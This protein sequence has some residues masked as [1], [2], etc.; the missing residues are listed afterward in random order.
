MPARFH[1]SSRERS[2]PPECQRLRAHL[3]A[4]V[5]GEVEPVVAAV[6]RAHITGCQRCGAAERGLRLL[7]AALRGAAEI[8]VL[9]PRR[10]RLAVEQ[11]FA[12]SRDG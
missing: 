9:A 7:T 12:D 11:Q 10:L 3:G 1:P 8:P 2:V 6:V 4:F 5:D